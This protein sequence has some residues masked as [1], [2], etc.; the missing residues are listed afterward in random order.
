VNPA[1]PRH[2]VHRQF[3]ER[4]SGFDVNDQLMHGHVSGFELN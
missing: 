4:S 1:A 3:N 2:H